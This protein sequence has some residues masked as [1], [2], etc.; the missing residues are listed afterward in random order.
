MICLNC[1]RKKNENEFFCRNCG[2]EYPSTG[3]QK[4]VVEVTSFQ[5]I[6]E[7]NNAAVSSKT[8]QNAIPY[9]TTNQVVMNN[10]KTLRGRKFLKVVGIIM[11]VFGGMA[12]LGGLGNLLTIRELEYILW[13][14]SMPYEYAIYSIIINFI[15]AITMLTTG[16]IGIVFSERKDKANLCMVFGIIN[17]VIVSFP[18]IVGV[19]MTNIFVIIIGI[20]SMILNSVLPILFLVGAVKNKNS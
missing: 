9:D 16:I 2:T 17:L 8:E 7:I 20:M 15:S 19:A 14:L 1:G 6:N 13:E 11:V 12:I 18:L 3:E 5:A 4:N 10:S